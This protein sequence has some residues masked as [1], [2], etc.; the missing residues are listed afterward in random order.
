MKYQCDA[1]LGAPYLLYIL[2][3]SSEIGYHYAYLHHRL[4]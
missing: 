2:L 3:L 4:S 1:D